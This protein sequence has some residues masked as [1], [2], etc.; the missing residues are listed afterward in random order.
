MKFIADLI[1]EFDA[2]VP[3][4]EP[5]VYPL[6][7]VNAADVFEVVVKAISDPGQEGQG[8]AGGTGTLGN[9]P[10]G[11]A[12][13]TGQNLFGG[14]GRNGNQSGAGGSFG[15]GSLEPAAVAAVRP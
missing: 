15:G 14:G 3:F 2:N 10:Q 6:K 7:H 11:G 1:E 9:R 13:T 12:A 5:S 8:G 4:G